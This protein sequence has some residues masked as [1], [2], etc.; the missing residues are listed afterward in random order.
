VLALINA[1]VNLKHR[2][3][4][5]TIYSGG[6]RVSEAINLRI[7]DIHSDDS[8]IFIKGGKGKRDRQTLLSNSLL[9]VLREYY[10]S[11]KPLYWLFEGQGGGRYTS[12]SIQNIFRRAQQKSKANPWSTP[13]TLRHSF[14]THLLENGENLRNIQALLGHSSSKTTEIYTHLVNISNNKIENPLDRMLKNN[15]F[16]NE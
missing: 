4:L 2:A 10:K 16:R 7:I 6:L 12:K 5:Y 3:I 15:T 9:K 1:P 11:H 14:A 8:Y 13:H